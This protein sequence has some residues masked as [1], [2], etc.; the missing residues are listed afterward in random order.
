MEAVVDE[1]FARHSSLFAP[2]WTPEGLERGGWQALLAR[3]VR[4]LSWG[5]Q[6]RIELVDSN[7]GG[8]GELALRHHHDGRDLDLAA[9]AEVLKSIAMLWG[10]RVWLHTEEEG[11]TRCLVS[12][13]R[14]VR[15]EG[16]ASTAVA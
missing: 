1:N 11:Q 16:S 14:E 10:R 7:H 13:G 9:A 12:D 4:E 2:A 6:P 5:G 8:V 3:L 15:L